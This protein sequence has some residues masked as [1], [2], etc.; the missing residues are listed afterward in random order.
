M[1]G[2]PIPTGVLFGP[3][4]GRYVAQ[5]DYKTESGYAWE[6]WDAEKD[7][8]V[9]VVDPG[10]DPDPSVH[11][12]AMVNSANRLAQQNIVAVQFQGEI[13]YRVCKEIPHGTELLTYYGDDY[14]KTL[15]IYDTYR[16]EA[17]EA[18]KDVQDSV[19]KEVQDAV[20]KEVRGFPCAGCGFCWMTKVGLDYHRCQG[21]KKQ[22]KPQPE[23][24]HHCNQCRKSFTDRSSL[25]RHIK[26]AH[27]MVR[28]QCE[29]CGR[30]FNFKE[31]LNLHVKTI[32][33]QDHWL[34][35]KVCDKSFKQKGDLQK[36]VRE[37]HE[38]QKPFKCTQC[39]KAFG[40]KAHLERHI[41]AVHEKLR[42]H[43]CQLCNWA[44]TRKSH[45][46]GHIRSIHSGEE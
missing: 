15:G 42:P 4:T 12:L 37:V 36:H 1:S 13:W 29:T 43:K 18:A 44:F 16:S 11:T 28:H 7:K 22:E 34:L 24:K 8:P 30:D 45:L 40:Q 6:I 25:S 23:K 9:G 39:V 17:E 21:E 38:G 41:Q 46:T 3:Y 2:S 33:T 35:C 32:H 14:S 10:S 5:K 31:N 19:A 27:M 20:A 26:S